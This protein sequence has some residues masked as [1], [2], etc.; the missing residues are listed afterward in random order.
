MD[1]LDPPY[2]VLKA[3]NSDIKLEFVFLNTVTSF[4]SFFSSSETIV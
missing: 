4:D 2:P 1:S 3:L